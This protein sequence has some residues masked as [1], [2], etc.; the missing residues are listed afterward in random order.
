M[1]TYKEEYSIYLRHF[2]NSKE[3]LNISDEIF[4]KKSLNILE[5]FT[6]LN[7]AR[8]RLNVEED[9]ISFSLNILRYETGNGLKRNF[10]KSDCMLTMAFLGYEYHKEICS[11]MLKSSSDVLKRSALLSLSCMDFDVQSFKSKK[12]LNNE[13]NLAWYIFSLY[14]SKSHT[15]KYLIENLEIMSEKSKVEFLCLICDYGSHDHYSDLISFIGNKLEPGKFIQIEPEDFIENSIEHG[16]FYENETEPEKLVR[17]YNN[18]LIRLNNSLSLDIRYGPK[19]WQHQESN[20][21]SE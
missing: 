8:E 14:N 13:I 3:N 5:R 12:F 21:K 1:I 16:K 19:K 15:T 18:A 2:F 9:F 10:I 7:E 6:C 11:K 17:A 20:A 4:F